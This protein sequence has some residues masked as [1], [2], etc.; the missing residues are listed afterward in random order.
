MDLSQAKTGTKT[1]LV[2]LVGKPGHAREAL[3]GLIST[4]PGPL[5]LVCADTGLL[6]LKVVRENTPRMA[7]IAGGLPCAEVLE[8]VRQIKQQWPQMACLV[9]AEKSEQQRDALLAGADYVMP[10]G[11]PSSQLLPVIQQLVNA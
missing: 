8:L 9:L 3:A 6:A 7:L 1:Q 4:L 5:G 2:L 11:M 10:P